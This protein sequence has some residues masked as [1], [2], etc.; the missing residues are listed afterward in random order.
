[1]GFVCN[2]P[3]ACQAG[4][5][6]TIT[7]A[8]TSAATP[9]ATG[10][11]GTTSVSLNFDANGS[12]PITV[13]Y[14]DVGQIT[15][16]ANMTA[17]P[18]SGATTVTLNGSSNAF[19]VKPDHY[20]LS[21]VACTTV[22]ASTCAPANSSGNNPAASNA[23]GAAFIQAGQPFTA[24]I[25]AMNK[26]NNPTPNY[27]N[28]SPP[29]GVS[30]TP[31]LVAPATGNISTLAN[32]VIGG[33]VGAFTNGAATVKTLSWGDV[34]IITLV[35]TPYDAGSNDYLGA[36]TV[37]GT[38]TG[39]GNIGRFIPDHF[40]TAIVQ[41]AGV[42]MPCPTN[43]TPLTC[44]T[45]YNGF[46]YS[47]QQ[48]SLQITAMNSSDVKTQNYDSTLG[49]SKVVSLYPYSSSGGTTLL[50]VGA[51]G[52]TSETVFASGMLTDATEKYTFSTALTTPTNGYICADDTDTHNS[53]TNVCTSSIEGG[54]TVASGRLNI[55][56]VYGS[57]LLPL[58]MA[59]TE[60]YYSSSGWVTSTTDSLT[61][62]AFPGSYSI[63][64]GTST[65][66]KNP[67]TGSLA[68]GLLTLNLSAPGS[69]HVGSALVVPTS[70]PLSYLP[71]WPS[72]GGTA[73]FGIYGGNNSIIYL[74]E[75]Y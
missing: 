62:L 35:A 7:N 8:T 10:S 61:S 38:Q 52:V 14:Y 50:T 16:N 12:A 46:V 53:I 1:M 74:H 3:A 19:V 36:G 6:V 25:T 58:T 33:V 26:L 20:D 64:G 70:T 65:V 75:N 39:V 30:L 28:E 11:P 37:T 9:I 73:T 57:E 55:P 49:F 27:G 31:T 34:G 48:F 43:P 18:F 17:T 63:G 69:G 44:P 15:L 24:T 29:Q 5:L 23:A 22:A 42:P 4:E 68:N 32:S 54:V 45:L 21:N 66:T 40:D 67:S 41:V 13:L 51:L 2:N 72:S 71:L 47:G 59:V 60:Q 56:N